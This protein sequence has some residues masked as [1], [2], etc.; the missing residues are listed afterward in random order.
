MAD[1]GF[2]TMAGAKAEG[3]APDVG[4]VMLGFAFLG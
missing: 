2:T 4:V 3:Q 1:T